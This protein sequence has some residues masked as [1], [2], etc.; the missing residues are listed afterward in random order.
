MNE[1]ININHHL[2]NKS[3]IKLKSVFTLA[4]EKYLQNPSRKNQSYF[5][6]IHQMEL[7]D[8]KR[9]SLK[10]SNT[11]NEFYK[12]NKELEVKKMDRIASSSQSQKELNKGDNKLNS[13]IKRV[14]S[15]D[16]NEGK[17]NEFYSKQL[18]LSKQKEGNLLS[19]KSKTDEKHEK[20]C[21]FK[22]EIDNNSKKIYLNNLNNTT[23]GSG[24][25]IA[26]V[27]ERLSSK[28]CNHKLKNKIN[29]TKQKIDNSTG[30]FNQEYSMSPIKA[31]INNS[32]NKS[33]IALDTSSS[34]FKYQDGYNKDKHEFLYRKLGLYK[35]KL[36]S[37]SKS[38]TNSK[39]NMSNS[40]KR[41][42]NSSGKKVDFEFSNIN[43]NPSIR[44]SSKNSLN[45][46][47]NSA[48]NFIN[49]SSS[50]L[51][52]Q[53]FIN[54]Y[55]D[56]YTEIKC[57]ED[58]FKL[59]LK[60]GLS[61]YDHI[62]NIDISKIKTEKTEKNSSEL[63]NNFS[64][65]LSSIHSNNISK[66][67]LTSVNCHKSNEYNLF[68]LLFK[69]ILKLSKLTSKIN[70]SSIENIPNN[71]H[72]VNPEGNDFKEFEVSPIKIQD[73]NSNDLLE[74]LKNNCEIEIFNNE[75]TNNN[76]FILVT[77][78]CTNT[79]QNDFE[80]IDSFDLFN[81]IFHIIMII[82]GF[83]YKLSR[84][85][86]DKEI[87]NLEDNN[88]SGINLIIAENEISHNYVKLIKN[89]PFLCS[90][91]YCTI[92]LSKQNNAKTR[93]CASGID[94]VFNNKQNN[95]LNN[96]YTDK[97]D[98][99][100]NSNINCNINYPLSL[101]HDISSVLN[102]LKTKK[103]NFNYIPFKN[104]DYI[105]LLPLLRTKFHL[106]SENRQKYLD[107]KNKERKN[108]KIISISTQYEN[109]HSPNLNQSKMGLGSEWRRKQHRMLRDSLEKGKSSD[110]KIADYATLSV[111][112]RNK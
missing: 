76:N 112:K 98:F 97:S 38:N 67:Q 40:T 11:G 63:I 50:L 64:S 72:N 75:N 13:Q 33:K 55:E 110:M 84:N 18:Q 44:S 24:I 78:N 6:L 83:Y 52:L 68:S 80:N 101:M 92:K 43:V 48:N 19:L 74:T 10:S 82:L 79:C 29:E 77:E 93:I 62:N 73:S 108:I 39:I 37:N 81:N 96:K 54:E 87:G 5:N 2:K 16:P 66:S 46:D 22:P 100:N 85:E 28:Y 36:G 34:K 99:K 41:V 107:I 71:S 49:K 17:F 102:S 91:F 26:N 90:F 27:H 7:N 58:F 59:L 104:L 86:N 45:N 51:F 35:N 47:I 89:D 88:K 53:K 42:N 65:N 60:L 1:T 3:E 61:Q 31:L 14:L 30:N 103:L 8:S 12:R 32:F 15:K 70:N 57:K 21:T 109:Q 9:I 94:N 111:I 106:L 56:N 4:S 25:S 23:M 69:I 105:D 20:S 95:L